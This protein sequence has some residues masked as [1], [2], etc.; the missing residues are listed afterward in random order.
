MP[1]SSKRNEKP[2]AWAAAAHRFAQYMLLVYR[3]EMGARQG[4]LAYR[5]R[6]NW[7]AFISFVND[8][9]CG[10]ADV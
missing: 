9:R 7:S 1:L 6:L 10:T 4:S 3:Q 2:L 8:W 5:D